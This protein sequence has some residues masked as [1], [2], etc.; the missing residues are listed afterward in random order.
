MEGLI[1]KEF[2]SIKMKAVFSKENPLHSKKEL[3]LEDWK[4]VSFILPPLN[5]GSFLREMIEEKF[6]NACGTPP[7]TAK[8]VIGGKLTYQLAAANLGVGIVPDIKE[9]EETFTVLKDLPFDLEFKAVAAWHEERNNAAIKNFL[10][11]I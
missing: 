4:S 3:S 2:F 5:S 8:E 10:A 11:Q 9:N 6:F 1:Y 7:R